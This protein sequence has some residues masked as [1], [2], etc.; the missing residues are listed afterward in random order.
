MSKGEEA[1]RGW[2][3]IQGGFRQLKP[4]CLPPAIYNLFLV[5]FLNAGNMLG[6]LNNIFLKV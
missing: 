5:C 3:A 6:Y 4:L 1:P 2:A